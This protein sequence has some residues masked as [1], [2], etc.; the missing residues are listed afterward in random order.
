MT[1]CGTETELQPS[2]LPGLRR[3]SA[4]VL[5]PSSGQ[6]QRWEELGDS[7]CSAEREGGKKGLKD[8]GRVGLQLA[9]VQG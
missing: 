7:R 4:P 6:S 8:R 1:F 5:K 9:D 3:R 2:L